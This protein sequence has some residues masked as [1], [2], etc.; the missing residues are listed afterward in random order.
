MS[1]DSKNSAGGKA[2]KP[3]AAKA[4]AA[5]TGA[6]TDAAVEDAVVLPAGGAPKSGAGASGAGASGAKAD[7]KPSAKPA[8]KPAAK[9]GGG[10]PLV[11][12]VIG[13]VV[14][15]VASLFLGP[16]LGGVLPSGYATVSEADLAGRLAALETQLDGVAAQS[17]GAVGAVGDS[18]SDTGKA[19]GAALSRIETL[20]AARP[21][22]DDGLAQATARIGSLE[23]TA[24][25]R[26]AR[27]AES[28]DNLRAQIATLAAAIAATPLVGSEGEASAP[29]TTRLA[30]IEGAV[31]QLDARLSGLSSEALPTPDLTRIDL[32]ETRI[33]ALEARPIGVG[34]DAAIGVAMAGLAQALAG[35]SPY[36]TE[37]ETLEKVIGRELNPSLGD[38]AASGL[39]SVISLHN[40]FGPASE[41]ALEAIAKDAAKKVDGDWTEA[42]TSRLSALVVIKR[43]GESDEDTPEG[44]VSRAEARLAEGD[45]ASALAE[46]D[47][48]PQIGKDA[49][50]GWLNDAYARADAEYAFAELKEELLGGR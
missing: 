44:A 9:S 35:S 7:P 12:G 6:A 20:E 13:G 48:L 47:A 19:L 41:T 43:A 15:A 11:P 26:E 10:S 42:L 22:V 1:D 3:G 21:G 29:V 34:G 40:R 23:Q 33:R 36:E 30:L 4:G 46:I 24:V 37:L 17:E 2:G 49:M 5:K 32:L 38:A 14:G 16:L 31:R 18:L 28:M 8:S 45:V 39:P 50:M 27:R 25:E